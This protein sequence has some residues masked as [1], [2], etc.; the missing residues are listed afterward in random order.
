MILAVT[1]L[2]ELQKNKSL[3]RNSKSHSETRSK[4]NPASVWSRVIYLYQVMENIFGAIKFDTYS[5]RAKEIISP[6]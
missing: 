1:E 6:N 4:N 2:S 3:N 5:E